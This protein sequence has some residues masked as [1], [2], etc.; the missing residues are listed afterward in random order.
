MIREFSRDY[1]S[2]GDAPVARRFDDT[3]FTATYYQDCMG[4]TFCHDVCCSFGADI[5]VD[6]IGRLLAEGTALE[7]FVGSKAAEWFRTDCQQ[8]DADSAGGAYTRTE[9]KDGRC[10]FLNRN[11]RGCLI[12]S[13]ALQR[14]SEVRELKP[15]VCS[16]FPVTVDHGTLRPSVEL[17][18]RDLICVGPGMT[19]Y[20][21]AR[22]DLEWYFGA[23]FVG[24]LDGF[25][26][27]VVG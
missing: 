13:Y 15:M 10:V 17:R 9:V 1:V 11:G 14:G 23:D 8:V 24:E 21:A 18:Q 26:R 3:I 19:A 4:C 16:V 22:A 6:N 20:R 5:D 2:R 12:H 27:Q 25:E 7:Q